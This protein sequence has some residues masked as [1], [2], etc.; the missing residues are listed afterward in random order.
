MSNFKPLGEF[1]AIERKEIE[2]T[3]AGG[4]ILGDAAEVPGEGTVFAVGDEVSE[5][6]AGDKVIFSPMQNAARSKI[7]KFEDKEFLVLKVEDIYCVVED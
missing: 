1:V 6:K 4:I 5:V 7:V 3:T 2:E